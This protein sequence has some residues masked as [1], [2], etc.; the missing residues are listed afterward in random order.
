MAENDLHVRSDVVP[1]NAVENL[2]SLLVSEKVAHIMER[3]DPA[4]SPVVNIREETFR[5]IIGSGYPGR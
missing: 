4:D 5:D 1:E 3:H 2:Q